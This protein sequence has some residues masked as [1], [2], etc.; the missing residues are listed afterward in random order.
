MNT[1]Q[2]TQYP[3][4]LVPSPSPFTPPFP[5]PFSSVKFQN[6]CSTSTPSEKCVE[7]NCHFSIQI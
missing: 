6:T 4:V 1:L 7:Y 2:R 5:P 3:I